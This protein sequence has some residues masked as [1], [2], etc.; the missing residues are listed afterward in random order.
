MKGQ[1]NK[2]ETWLFPFLG[3]YLAHCREKKK[4]EF[5][6]SRSYNDKTLVAIFL[7]C[8]AYVTT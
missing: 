4:K 7:H 2:P 3:V 8:K 5:V 6:S 1:R